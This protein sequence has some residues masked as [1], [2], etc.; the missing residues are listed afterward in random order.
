MD[1]RFRPDLK[2]G[3]KRFLL[4]ALKNQAKSK[5]KQMQLQAILEPPYFA[6]IKL[7]GMV[8]G[9]MNWV[10]LYRLY[11]VYSDP[12]CVL[13]IPNP[14]VVTGE[15]HCRLRT[16]TFKELPISALHESVKLSVQLIATEL[17]GR[18]IDPGPSRSAII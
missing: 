7:K 12:S 3:N 16:V 14:V 17:K 5:K 6:T 2:P 1:L 4:G 8:R 11:Q 13:K 15:E 18:I 10:T 9:D